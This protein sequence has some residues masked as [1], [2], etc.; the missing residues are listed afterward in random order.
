MRVHSPALLWHGNQRPPPPSPPS[1]QAAPARHNASTLCGHTLMQMTM[2]R[3][4]KTRTLTLAARRA[5]AVVTAAMAAAGLLPCQRAHAP[6][7]PLL[8]PFPLA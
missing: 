1:P 6:L 4:T 3:K 8:P 2:M 7:P 5:T